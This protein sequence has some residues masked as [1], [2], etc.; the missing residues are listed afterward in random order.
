MPTLLTIT[1][2]AREL[3]VRPAEVQRLIARGVLTAN[4]VGHREWRIDRED[5]AAYVRAGGKDLAPPPDDPLGAY[6]QTFENRL[7][8]AAADQRPSD[9][10]LEGLVTPEQHD[11]TIELRFSPELA[12]VVK[13]RVDGNQFDPKAEQVTARYANWG[14]LFAVDR[15][16]SVVAGRLGSSWQVQLY[17]TPSGYSG[18]VTAA[19]K[20]LVSQ[21]LAWRETRSV[22]AGEGRRRAV[23]VDYHLS[24][25]TFVDTARLT[26]AEQLAF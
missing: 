15:L 20:A 10:R 1:D 12:A 24:V 7:F 4:Q 22:S 21:V 16:R 13:A 8:A 5:L 19:Y 11:L 17:S 3:S 18:I 14:D 23:R 2:V 26:R 25:G 9:A 6:V